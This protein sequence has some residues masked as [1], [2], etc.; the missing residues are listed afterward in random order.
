MNYTYDDWLP[1]VTVQVEVV[2]FCQVGIMRF[3]N[4]DPIGFV[5]GMNWYAYASGNPVSRID[6]QGT[7]DGGSTIGGSSFGANPLSAEKRGHS[8]ILIIYMCRVFSLCLLIWPEVYESRKRMAC[9][10]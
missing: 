7:A 3:I 9:I 6:P 4:A 2:H 8:V 1:L 5:G 10:T